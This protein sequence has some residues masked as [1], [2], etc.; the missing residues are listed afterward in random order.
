MVEPT[1]AFF[2]HG[3]RAGIC[4]EA[5]TSFFRTAKGTL[6]PLCPACC[7]RHKTVSVQMLRQGRLPTATVTR[8]TFDIPIDA[9]SLAT[10]R[11]Q[12]P[13]RIQTTLAQADEKLLDALKPE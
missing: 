5:A 8:A 11:A 1:C 7:D 6:W 9:E 10:F 3:H 13:S 4:Q 12:D 2:G